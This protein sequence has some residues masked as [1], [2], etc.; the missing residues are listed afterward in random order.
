MTATPRKIQV[1]IRPAEERDVPAIQQIAREAWDETYG[2]TVGRLEREKILEHLCSRQSLLEDIGRHES[3]F[4]VAALEDGVVGFAEVVAEGRAG[5]V[6]RLAVLPDWQRRGVAT[7]LLQRGLAALAAGGAREVTTAIEIQDV[8]CRQL[9]ERNGFEAVEA[10]VAEI[11]ELDDLELIQLRRSL[12]DAADLEAA[13]EATVWVEDGHRPSPRPN[14]RFVTVLSTAD[15]SR[16]SFVESA[17][18]GAGI[19]YVVHESNGGGTEE[20]LVEIQVADSRAEEAR[21][22][23]EALEGVEVE[24]ADQE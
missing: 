14:H 18:E 9:F 15:E 12:D 24:L 16:L 20:G 7:S 8:G 10:P 23:L 1:I 5:E 19:V 3:Y 13:A 6:A 4:F 11:E 2:G 17:L 21:E 22:V